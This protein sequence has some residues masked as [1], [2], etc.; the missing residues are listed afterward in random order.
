MIEIGLNISTIRIS[1]SG[2]NWPVKKQR[3]I[4]WEKCIYMQFT[5]VTLSTGKS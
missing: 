3:L 1:A 4:N 2:I 5:I